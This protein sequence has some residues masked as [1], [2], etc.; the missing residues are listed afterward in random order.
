MFNPFSP[1]TSKIYGAVAIAALLALTVQTARVASR[2]VAITELKQDVADRTRERDQANTN[3]R[4]TKANYAAA[5]ARA[6]ELDR[7]RLERV[8]AEQQEIT[9]E[10]VADYRRRLAAVRAEFERLR[11]EARAGDGAGG[12]TDAER[13][14]AAGGAASGAA[15]AA[16]DRGFPLNERLIATEQ[17]LQLQALIDW[18]LRQGRVDPN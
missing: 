11:G 15:E 16:G 6:A 9:D 13:V 4:Q 5:Q 1:L 7:R 10:A 12:T 8:L 14:P 17:A 2:D 3:H 18:V